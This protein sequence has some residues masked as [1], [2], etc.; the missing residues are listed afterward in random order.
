M[1]RPSGVLSLV[2]VFAMACAESPE[3][4]ATSGDIAEAG[5]PSS[6][7]DD[8][9]AVRAAVEAHWTAI[10]NGDTAAIS[11]QHTSDMTFFGPE[12]AH[13]VTLS[14]DAP[15]TT[16][17]WQRFSGTTATWAPRDVQVQMFDDV[18]VAAFFND[19][20]VTYADGTTDARTRRVTEV[21]VRQ[22]DGTWKEAHH[23]DSPIT[24]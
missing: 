15:E 16:A 5:G 6:V 8:V 11:N 14:S 1:Q 9:A 18:A 3:P 19:G 10:A 2:V 24:G 21:W 22:S 17:L 12:S 23:H 20:S 7:A 4:S 13:L